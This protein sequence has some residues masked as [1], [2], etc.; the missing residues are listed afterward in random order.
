MAI[1]ELPK[2]DLDGYWFATIDDK[3]RQVRITNGDTDHPLIIFVD[4]EKIYELCDT[5]I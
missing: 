4:Y 5:M 1:T 3:L 2:V